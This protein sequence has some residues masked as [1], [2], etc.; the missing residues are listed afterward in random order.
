M[1]FRWRSKTKKWQIWL[2]LH[3][4]ILEGKSIGSD[5]FLKDLNGELMIWRTEMQVRVQGIV[6]FKDSVCY[7]LVQI[8]SSEFWPWTPSKVG[9]RATLDKG[10]GTKSPRTNLKQIE[11]WMGPFFTLKI[12]LFSKVQWVCL[13]ARLGI[14][15]EGSI[16]K[17]CEWHVR[18]LGQ[19]VI[20]S[21]FFF[22]F[23]MVFF[24]NLFYSENAFLLATTLWG[25]TKS[26]MSTPKLVKIGAAYVLSTM[27]SICSI[28]PFLGFKNVWKRA[29][30]KK[31]TTLDPNLHSGSP[32]MSSVL[33][34]FFVQTN[35]CSLQK[36]AM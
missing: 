35:W 1:T 29:K 28:L 10:S 4:T 34:F 30:N 21:P 3:G 8:G 26:T 31:R 18:G 14:Q 36:D 32:N 16:L 6:Q 27:S 17:M 5:F 12:T 13:K 11:P 24:I 19:C 7:K 23:F 9:L 2:N 25:C 33:S 20:F 22:L 15:F